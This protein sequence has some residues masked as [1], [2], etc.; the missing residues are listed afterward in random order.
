MAD[1]VSDIAGSLK[2]AARAGASAASSAGRDL[3]GDVETFVVPHLQDIAV[4]VASIVEKH[5]AG[6]FTDITAQTLLQS[7]CDA[8]KTLVETATTLVVLEVQQICAAILDALSGAVNKAVGV[9]LL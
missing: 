6:I 2:D 8:V 4:Q 9:A 1:L 3:T 7:E 5:T